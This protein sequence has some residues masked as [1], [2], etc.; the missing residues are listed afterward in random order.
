MPVFDMEDGDQLVVGDDVIFLPEIEHALVGIG[1]VFDV[2]I[3][4][5]IA[6]YDRD[7]C[8]AGLQEN[9]KLN[10]EEE[11]C[12]DTC[13]HWQDALEWF[14]YN[15]LGSLRSGEIKNPIFIHSLRKS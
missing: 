9:F 5:S 4:H 7:E 14:S 8:V 12:E 13:D 3:S 10:C 6:V 15:I 1:E 2:N 11:S